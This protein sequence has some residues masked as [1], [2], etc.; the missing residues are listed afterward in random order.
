MTYRLSKAGHRCTRMRDEETK[1]DRQRN[2][3]L[4]IRRDHPCCRIENKFCVVGSLGGV[5]LSFTFQQNQ[6]SGFRYCFGNSLYYRT[7]SRD[8]W[9]KYRNG[10]L[11]MM[12]LPRCTKVTQTDFQWF[13]FVAKRKQL[14]RKWRGVCDRKLRRL[15]VFNAHVYIFWFYAYTAV[16]CCLYL[17]LH[18]RL[19]CWLM[20]MMNTFFS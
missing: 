15:N 13:P 11:R 6:S 10:F 12:C 5:A 16:L 4:S 3:T 2:L 20:S 7:V 9:R 17:R 8:D 14:E 18:L 19:P 1:K